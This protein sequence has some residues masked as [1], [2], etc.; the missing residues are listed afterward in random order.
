MRLKKLI[1]VVRI[2][3]AYN[4]EHNI[5]PTTIHKE[6]RDAIRGQEVIMMLKS[7]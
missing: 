3:D 4:K 6:I 2:Q 7:S 5:T 1:V